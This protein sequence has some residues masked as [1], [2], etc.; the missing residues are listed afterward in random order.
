MSIER[1]HFRLLVIRAEKH[2]LDRD[3]NCKLYSILPIHVKVCK[4]LALDLL[5]NARR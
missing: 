4:L 1:N 3:V 2:V 5:D